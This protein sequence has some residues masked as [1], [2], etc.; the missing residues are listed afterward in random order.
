MSGTAMTVRLNNTLHDFVIANISNSGTYENVSEYIRSLIR[1]DKEQTE[2]ATFLQLQA[3]LQ[4]AFQAPDS[5]Y[6]PL[7]ANDIIQRN[8]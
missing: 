1:R 5:S 3:E 2:Q 8:T 7:T 6:Q 4:H